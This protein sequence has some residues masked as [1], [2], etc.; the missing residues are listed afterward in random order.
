MCVMEKYARPKDVFENVCNAKTVVVCFFLHWSIWVTGL[1]G[2]EHHFGTRIVWG[3]I[4][5]V[6]PV[7]ELLLLDV[8]GTATEKIRTCGFRKELSCLDKAH[9]IRDSVRLN[10][11]ESLLV[12][13]FN[14]FRNLGDALFGHHQ[15]RC[16]LWLI[17]P[18]IFWCFSRYCR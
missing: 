1:T 11:W 3:T 13:P 17:V 15:I 8:P 10:S 9:R 14:S 16:V 2:R 12:I 18:C 5:S 7:F 6:F 4:T